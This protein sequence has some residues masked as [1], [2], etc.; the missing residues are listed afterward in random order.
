M[1]NS[2]NTE[3][4]RKKSPRKSLSLKRNRGN[5]QAHADQELV[6]AKVIKTGETSTQFCRSFSNALAQSDSVLLCGLDNMGNTCYINSVI[7][8]LRFSPGFVARLS[9][10][11]R[12]P[13]PLDC[14]KHVS[15]N[16]DSLLVNGA[17]ASSD[18]YPRTCFSFKGRRW[19][20]Q[21]DR[22]DHRLVAGT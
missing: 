2:N 13:R 15:E 12:E 16:V 21:R 18:V 8:C 3:A 14:G 1:T 7:Q 11:R 9:Q 4:S 20:R 6:P 17:Q 10:L 5:S 22:C 19:L